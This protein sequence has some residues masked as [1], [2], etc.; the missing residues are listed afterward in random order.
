MFT[1]KLFRFWTENSY[2]KTDFVPSKSMVPEWYR[3]LSRKSDSAVEGILPVPYTAKVCVP[4]LDGLL[5]GFMI[6]TSHD[7]G[8]K[9]TPDG[10]MFTWETF[11]DIA[12]PTLHV[13]KRA[14]ASG[15][16]I[17]DHMSKSE[18]VWNVPFAFEGPKGYSA[19][20]THPL[21]RFDLPFNTLSGVVDLDTV[22]GPGAFPFLISK[23][24]EGIIPAGTPV[25]Q[26][27]PF[28]R[29]NWK[30]EFDQKLGEKT[31][32]EKFLYR[33]TRGRYKHE[34]WTPKTYE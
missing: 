5:T 23:T 10:P 16:P 17:P 6:L 20:L 7:I 30:K 31:N 12:S 26:I 8:V 11:D 29:D 28:K 24:F 34:R 13:S 21:N 18:F 2:I 25:V 3:K 14:Y 32:K 9:Q 1:N 4:F 19:L 22:L 15:I 33:K 27:L